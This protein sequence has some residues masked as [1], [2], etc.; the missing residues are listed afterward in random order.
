MRLSTKSRYSLRILVQ[1]ALEMK[2]TP[3]VKGRVIAKKQEISEPYLEQIMI[4][5]KSSELVRTIRGCN[6]G[7]SLNKSPEDITILDIIELFE[8]KIEF[9]ECNNESTTPCSLLDRCPT[10]SVW[11]HLSKTLRDEAAKI[12]LASILEK[13][14]GQ[15]QEYVI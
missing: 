15:T 2:A 7:Y 11:A 8:G 4:P 13:V 14:E 5:L 1:L 6:G 3:A 9:A 10:S 12:S